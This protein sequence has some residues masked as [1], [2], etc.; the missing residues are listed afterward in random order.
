MELLYRIDR[1]YKMIYWVIIRL[2]RPIFRNNG[3]NITTNICRLKERRPQRVEHRSSK[4]QNK[5]LEYKDGGNL[6]EGMKIYY[7]RIE[8]KYFTKTNIGN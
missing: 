5:L 3:Y 8:G 1:L 2:S 6:L 4:Y 7:Q